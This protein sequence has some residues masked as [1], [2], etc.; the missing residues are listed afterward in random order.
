MGAITGITVAERW[1]TG[2]KRHVRGTFTFST[3]YA[4]GGDTGLTPAALGIDSID[5]MDFTLEVGLTLDY[6]YAS[7]NVIAYW[8][9]NV[10]AANA[11]H[12][13]VDNTTNLGTT[14]PRFHC[15]GS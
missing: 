2:N 9:D 11:A 15:W 3:S 8:D 1:V 4:T 12:V 13:E 5:Q 6:V 7:G 10:A 14:I